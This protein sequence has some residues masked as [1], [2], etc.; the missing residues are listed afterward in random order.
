MI[1]ELRL[2]E[3]AAANQNIAFTAAANIGSISVT[4]AAT[5]GSF[6]ELSLRFKELA[7]MNAANLN[8]ENIPA[9]PDVGKVAKKY[10]E[11]HEGMWLE[12]QCPGEESW[13]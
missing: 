6:P 7:S 11:I 9:P 10:R 4:V 5:A 8:A 3:F 13:S 12:R 2:I 1:E